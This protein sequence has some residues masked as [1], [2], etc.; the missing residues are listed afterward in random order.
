MEQKRGSPPACSPLV[1]RRILLPGLSRCGVPDGP[2]TQRGSV[3]IGK[4]IRG[5]VAGQDRQPQRV[6]PGG[7]FRPLFGRSKRGPPDRMT[8]ERRVLNNVLSSNQ[9]R[10]RVTRP[11]C[12]A[13][14]D[15]V[16]EDDTLP[17]TGRWRWPMRLATSTTGRASR[18]PATG[19]ESRVHGSGCRT[20]RPERRS[21]DERLADGGK[22]VGGDAADRPGA[23]GKVLDER[24]G[25][26]RRRRANDGEKGERRMGGAESMNLLRIPG[27]RPRAQV[28]DDKVRDNDLKHFF[29]L[30]DGRCRS[31]G[32]KI[33]LPVD[34]KCRTLAAD[35][36]GF[37][38]QNLCRGCD[39][40]ARIRHRWVPRRFPHRWRK[41]VGAAGRS[42]H[43]VAPILS[44]SIRTHWNQ[45]ACRRSAGSVRRSLRRA[46]GGGS[47]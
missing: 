46:A 27:L 14:P 5:P 36:M 17:R 19:I 38:N 16:Q 6:Q 25:S 4:P 39:R 8:G 18:Q 47:A 22:E 30:R 9:P 3:R 26:G 11:S 42:T 24:P 28:D 31:T 21:F 37:H 45:N 34:E 23:A 32:G 35:R 43:A 13:I 40:N 10:R 33:G 12:A 15:Q 7:F 1:S 20:R 2:A 41:P 44:A 29:G